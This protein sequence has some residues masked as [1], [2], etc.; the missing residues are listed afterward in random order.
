MS[1]RMG[2][3]R[4]N[5]RS[6]GGFTFVE[7]LVALLFAGIVMV[8][9]YLVFITA[10]R[11]YYAQEQIVQMQESMRFALEYVKNDLRSVGRLSVVNGIEL[12][13]RVDL[14]G[15]D[16][17]FCS[18]RSGH[19]AIELL[20]RPQDTPESL[21]RFG[22]NLRPDRLRLL[23]DRSEGVTYTISRVNRR[24]V[25][26][27]LTDQRTQKARES[28]TRFMYFS[29]RAY[30]HIVSPSGQSDLVVAEVRS[31][32]DDEVELRLSDDLCLAGE[33]ALAAE[34][35]PGGCLITPV[36]LV[37]YAIL[38]ATP[39]FELAPQT[40]DATFLVRRTLDPVSL[41]PSEDAMVLAPY[42]VNFQVWASYDTRSLAVGA[43]P[44]P[45]IP[46]DQDP[47]DDRGN[48]TTER[49]SQILNERP[50]RIRGLNVM[51]A[52]RTPREDETFRVA[53]D[54][55]M[56]AGDRIGADRS[57]FELSQD[58]GTG[59]ARVM[60]LKTEVETPN[61]YRGE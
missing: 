12:G 51:L 55:A 52:I 54:Q 26:L 44:R 13:G 50:Q 3:Q 45:I 32:G 39:E 8:A 42:A 5:M 43:D 49:E 60:T 59:L 14:V 34:C 22:N 41:E 31:R 11:Q 48:W 16:P 18:T 58:A 27:N 24:Q 53:P 15:R 46:Q 30:V 38:E 35:A 19:R 36:Q 20:E 40:D 10:S 17:R 7:L 21:I 9:A 4:I 47:T 25:L 29:D 37:E 23:V 2:R 56:A 6:Q 28:L 33:P 57:W 1:V 61:M